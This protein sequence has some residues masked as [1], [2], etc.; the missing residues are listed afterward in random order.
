MKKHLILLFMSLV[1]V[2]GGLGISSLVQADNKDDGQNEDEKDERKP[3]EMEVTLQKHYIDGKVD[4]DTHTETIWAMEDFWSYYHG[5]QVMDQQEG[6]IIFKK[7]VSDISP[8]LK[9]K[10]YFGLKNDILTIFNG[11]PTHE[12]VIQSFYQI[13]TSELESYQT[14]QLQDGIKIESK[15]VYQYVLEAYRDM[16]PSRSVSS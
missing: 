7:E 10:G 11:R 15:E 14:K 16:A 3:L 6:S 9:E 5:W 2:F 1:V 12:Q 4:E 13:D 8:Y